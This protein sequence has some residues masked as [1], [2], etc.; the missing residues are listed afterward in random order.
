MQ[1]HQAPATGQLLTPK[2]VSHQHSSKSI[3]LFQKIMFGQGS[4]SV[5]GLGCQ[6]R[7]L[8]Q[9]KCEVPGICKELAE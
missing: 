9:E 2:K 7:N 6:Y 1:L 5:Q 3:N 8:L 4:S